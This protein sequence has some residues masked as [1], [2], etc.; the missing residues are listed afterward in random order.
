MT[1]GE[2]FRAIFFANP[3]K[4]EKIAAA[5]SVLRRFHRDEKTTIMHFGRA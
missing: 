1:C 5:I 3:R 4:D 2:F